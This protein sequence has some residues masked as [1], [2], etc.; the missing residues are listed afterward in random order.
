MEGKTGVNKWPC[1]V[2]TSEFEIRSMWLQTQVPNVTLPRLCSLF[3]E[4][5]RVWFLPPVVR[6]GQ[7]STV[8]ARHMGRAHSFTLLTTNAPASLP[9]HSLQYGLHSPSIHKILDISILYAIWWYLDWA[10]L[11]QGSRYIKSIRWGAILR[12]PRNRTGRL[13]SPSQI[14]QKYISTLSKL[15]KTTSECWQR[16]SGTQKSGSLSSKTGRKNI[17]DGKK[18][19]KR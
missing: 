1:A 13:L 8:G 10:K 9:S 18:R 16:T 19:Q 17:K 11:R 3:F 4:V 7:D 14:H 15:H 6:V 5:K 2:E 12:W